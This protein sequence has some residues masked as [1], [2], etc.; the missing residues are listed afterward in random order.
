[1]TSLHPIL[2]T[3][4]TLLARA[5]ALVRLMLVVLA[6]QRALAQDKGQDTSTPEVFAAVDPYTRNKPEAFERAGYVSLGPFPFS[7]GI[8]TKEVEESLGGLRVLWVET[9]HFK[10]G[11]LLQTY[12]RGTDDLEEKKLADELNRLAK[13]LPHVRPQVRELDPWLRLHLFALRLE[14]EYADFEA[15]A[16]VTDADFGAAPKGPRGSLTDM[17]PGKFLGAELKFTVMLTEK[18][19]QLQRFARR[20]IKSDETGWYITEL[21]G[22]SWLFATAAQITQELGTPLDSALHALVADGVAECFTYAYRG[23]SR[24]RPFWLVHGLG[25]AY[26]RKAEPRWSVYIPRDSPGPEDETWKWEE[27]VSGLV[28]NKF[29]PTWDE[30]LAWKSPVGMESRAHIVAWSRVAWLMETE[31][32]GLQVY[33]RAI[34]QPPQEGSLDTP[35]AAALTARQQK[36]LSDAFSKT[37]AELDEAWKKWVRRK[38]PKK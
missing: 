3:K 18:N 19:T 35:E 14:E 29:V 17:G 24:S 22:G 32:A 5:I 33:L 8:Q 13:K 36:Q 31:P 6:G 25:L 27:R 30:M 15:R 37:P 4:K 28:T 38:Y 2:T 26:G 16:G 7:E 20:W 23:F 12:R 11:S 34:S 10:L 9:Q 21:Q 1:V